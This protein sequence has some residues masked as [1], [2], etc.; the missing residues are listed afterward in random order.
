MLGGELLVRGFRAR[1]GV[2]HGVKGRRRWG[3]YLRR[4]SQAGGNW[5]IGEGRS[6]VWI[7][8]EE[9]PQCWRRRDRMTCFLFCE[10][11]GRKLVNFG[12]LEGS[13]EKSRNLKWFFSLVGL[14]F[15]TD[16]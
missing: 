2:S 11:K 9:V 15:R 5:G 13:R 14:N 10:V 4:G 8:G 3:G 7:E 16:A 6:E 1:E 12:E